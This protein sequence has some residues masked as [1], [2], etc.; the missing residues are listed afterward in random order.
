MVLL[1]S[2]KN[3]FE[4]FISYCLSQNLSYSG[5]HFGFPIDTKI[6]NFERDH[7]MIIQVQFGFNQIFSFWKQKKFP[8][9][10][11]FKTLFSNSGHLEF[12]IY[13]KQIFCKGPSIQGTFQVSIDNIWSYVNT[14]PCSGGHIYFPVDKKKKRRKLFRGS[15]TK[16][17]YHVTI[18]SH[19]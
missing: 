15:E 13:T 6:E 5:G 17:S 2:D 4:I 18:L 11:Y 8:L 12:L 1:Y 3:S 16:P 14:L 19:M 7:P 10:F 9:R